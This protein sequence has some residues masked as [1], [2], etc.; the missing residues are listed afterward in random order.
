[1]GGLAVRIIERNWYE[2]FNRYIYFNIYVI[3]GF[4]VLH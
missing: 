1:M 3:D 2:T 4:L